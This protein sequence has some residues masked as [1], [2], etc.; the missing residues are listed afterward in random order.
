M[1]NFSK[2][3]EWKTKRFI[4]PIEMFWKKNLFYHKEDN[5]TC[6]NDS[7]KISDKR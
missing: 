1:R 5:L 7:W 4:N 6:V 2:L 3:V